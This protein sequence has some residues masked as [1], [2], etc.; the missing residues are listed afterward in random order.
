PDLVVTENNRPAHLFRNDSPVSNRY[1][2]VVLQ[3]RRPNG[4][5]I[6]ARVVVTAGGTRPGGG[7]GGG[8]RGQPQRERPLPL[9][10]GRAPRAGPAD[11]AVTWPRGGAT[12]RKGVT[13]NQT[14]TIREAMSDE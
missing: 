7:G 6:G 5:A 8:G 14:I 2:R 4:S 12:E 10:R 3:G 11:V 13:T 1:L 9:G